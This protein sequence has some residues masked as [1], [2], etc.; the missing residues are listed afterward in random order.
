MYSYR[1]GIILNACKLISLPKDDH[2]HY[3]IPFFAVTTD[4]GRISHVLVI[5]GLK[6]IFSCLVG[7]RLILIVHM[8]CCDTSAPMDNFIHFPL[9]LALSM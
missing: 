9:N 3:H 4:N 2:L 5:I 6:S 1:A 7:A 8:I